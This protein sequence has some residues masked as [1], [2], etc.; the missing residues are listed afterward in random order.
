MGGKSRLALGLS[1]FS[2]LILAGLYFAIKIW[3]PFMWVILMP[4]VLGFIAWFYLEY[5]NI[6]ELITMKSTKQGLNMGALV[7]IAIC[8]LV[9]INYLG[10]KYYKTFDYSGN[11]FNTLS[12]QSQKIINNLDSPLVVKFF[13]K[14]GVEH[15]DENKKLFRDLIKKYQ[16]VSDKVQFEFI[17]MNESAKLAKDFG[18]TKGAGE[19][20]IDFKGNKNRIENYTEQDFTN[21]VI[22]VTRTTKKIIYFVTGH[23]ERDLEQEKDETGIS[24]FKQML[25]KN[26]Y[27]TKSL[28]LI[29][30]PQIPADANAVV[31][32]G[33]QQNFQ[34]LEIK[35]LESY[36]EKGGSLLIALDDR[37]S[38]G[39]LPILNSAGLDYQKLYIFNVYNTPMGQVVNAQSPTVAVNY[40]SAS[41]ITKMFG[42]KEM[43][44]FRQPQALTI[45][46]LPESMKAEVLVKT[47]ETSVALKELDSQDYTGEPQSYNLGI[48][49]RGKFGKSEKDFDLIVFS[50]AD[51]MSNILL[52][53]NLNRDLAMNSIATLA[54]ENDLISVSAKEVGPTKLLVAPPEFNQFFK[55]VIG[56]VFLPIPV[57]LMIISLVLWM[58]RR[59]A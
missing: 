13:Y 29:A 21:A 18:A 28:S 1:L 53:Q 11:S 17:E 15:V 46:K 58:R 49:V 48:E 52:Y 20:F 39:L 56:G 33:P 5:K 3:M 7:L 38:A 51:F 57:V 59:H 36:L 40:S 37:N 45:T 19:A 43:T 24:S 10:A 2:F 55:F 25:E 42:P 6:Y 47:P 9:V 23:K 32:A 14:N 12:E 27:I 34:P 8:F 31:I 22:K 16:D 35:A 41:E 44:V 26:S 4:A 54:K 30:E 50:D